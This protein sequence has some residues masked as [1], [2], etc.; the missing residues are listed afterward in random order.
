MI[1]GRSPK[2]PG[3]ITYR[4]TAGSQAMIGESVS[5]SPFW[6]SHES[7]S[8]EVSPPSDVVS[9]LVSE[10]TTTIFSAGSSRQLRIEPFCNR[11]MRL[12]CRHTS[13]TATPRGGRV[14]RAGLLSVSGGATMAGDQCRWQSMSRGLREPLSA[15]R[16]GRPSRLVPCGCRPQADP[17]GGQ[18]RR[19]GCYRNRLC[20]QTRGTMHG[21]LP[22]STRRSSPGQPT[23]IGTTSDKGSP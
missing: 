12:W 9:S 10:G 13:R 6:S 1:H 21:R 4:T 8:S 14:G 5:S 23:T 19:P 3:A 11:V 16:V 17:H 20:P 18:R 22:P 7:S 2:Q 15:A